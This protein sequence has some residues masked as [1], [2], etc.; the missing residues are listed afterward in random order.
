VTNPAEPAPEFDSAGLWAA[1]DA[2]RRARDISWRQVMSEINARSPGVTARLGARDHPMSLSTVMALRRGGVGSCQHAL[3]MLQWLGQ[4]PERF[5]PGAPADAATLPD[6]GPDRR[7]RWDLKALHAALA[8]ERG[9]RG[10]TWTDVS[11]EI[12]C[13]PGQLTGLARLRYGTSMTLAMRCAGWLGRSAASLTF[14]AE[15]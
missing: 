5:M 8:A 4:A 3:G 2:H 12:G 9:R 1:I 15:R 11:R 14:A 7:L 6:V 13:A 10:L